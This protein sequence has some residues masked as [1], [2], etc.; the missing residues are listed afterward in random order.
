MDLN[1]TASVLVPALTALLS[2]Y[3]GYRVSVWQIK[4]EQVT[5]EQQTE[6]ELWRNLREELN[7]KILEVKEIQDKYILL[8]AS[9]RKTLQEKDELIESIK[10]H[11]RGQVNGLRDEIEQLSSTNHRQAIEIGYLKVT[12]EAINQRQEA[13]G[14]GRRSYD[15]GGDGRATIPVIVPSDGSSGVPQS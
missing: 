8:E 14:G 12:V 7:R 1:S 11:Y 9:T 10:N 3:G 6:N 4:K 5:Q 13:K 15:L 2:G